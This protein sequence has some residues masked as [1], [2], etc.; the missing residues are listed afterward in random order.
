[1]RRTLLLLVAQRVV[2]QLRSRP[3]FSR[4][5]AAGMKPAFLVSV[6]VLQQMK[7]PAEALLTHV[8]HKRLVCF[9]DF[10]CVLLFDDVCRNIIKMTVKK[11]KNNY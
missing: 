1:M 11:Y 6:H 4:T 8:T 3:E 7:A 5:L 2:L 9:A 10:W